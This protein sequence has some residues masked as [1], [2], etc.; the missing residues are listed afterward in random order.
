VMG[1]AFPTVGAGE[2]L[3][4][5]VSRLE[6]APAVLVVDR[7]H[8]IGVVTRSDVLSALASRS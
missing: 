2:P 7:G 3:D 6:G 5:A 8:P 1:P 4:V